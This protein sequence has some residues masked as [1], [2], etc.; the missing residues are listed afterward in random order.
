MIR[1][2]FLERLDDLVSW[3]GIPA[4]SQYPPRRRPLRWPATLALVLAFGGAIAAM[5][6]GVNTKGYWIGYTVLMIGFSIGNFTNIFGPLKPPA[7]LFERADEWDRSVRS[8]SYLVTFGVFAATV[9]LGLFA[10]MWAVA[11]V[12][13]SL[14]LRQFSILVFLLMTI[15]TTTPTAYASWRWRWDDDR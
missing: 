9:F 12:P 10:M 1:K 2:T 11:L 6:L 8:Q 13:T 5:A 4:L 3:T 7:S 15:L 14:S